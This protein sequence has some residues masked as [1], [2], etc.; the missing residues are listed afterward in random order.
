[1]QKLRQERR[2]RPVLLRLLAATAQMH[3]SHSTE[4]SADLRSNRKSR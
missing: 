1:M 2:R 4:G 3:T